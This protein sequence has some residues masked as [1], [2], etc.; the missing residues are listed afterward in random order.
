MI[1]NVRWTHSLATCFHSSL[2][3]R[4]ASPQH[5]ALCRASVS[6]SPSCVGES[7]TSYRAALLLAI[8]VCCVPV[9]RAVDY[10]LILA[11]VTLVR[12]LSVLWS[13]ACVSRKE[14][15]TQEAVT[16]TCSTAT[17]AVKK[18]V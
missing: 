11:Q 10:V 6:L 12:H 9:L 16:V 5:N 1:E 14:A 8:V 2:N 3:R 4:G 17:R 7:A 15:E 13:S 18:A